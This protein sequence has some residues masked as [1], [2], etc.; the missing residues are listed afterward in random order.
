MC[1]LFALD[2]NKDIDITDY[3]RIFYSHSNNH[4]NG[5]GLAY[6]DDDNKVLYKEAVKADDSNLLNCI[7]S[8]RVITKKLLAHIRL[9]TLGD[10]TKCNCHPFE[11]KD[12]N[13]RTWTLIHNGTIFNF[14]PLNDYKDIQRGQTDSERLLY[15]IIDCINKKENNEKLNDLQLCEYMDT[16]IH[17]LSKNNKLNLILANDKIMFIHSNCKESLYYLDKKDYILISTLALCDDDWM[18][19]DL[20]T[21]Y[22]IGNAEII[23]SGRKHE[24]EY[25]ISEDNVN[26]ILDSLSDEALEELLASYGSIENIKNQIHNSHK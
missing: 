11:K 16:L 10:M 21:L 17:R 26:F 14:P 24:N 15:Y 18:E 19:V 2:A 7:L 1:E 8:D 9:A 5:W 6:L 25:V 3:L 20:N 12:N 4:P 23:F 22:A 13:D